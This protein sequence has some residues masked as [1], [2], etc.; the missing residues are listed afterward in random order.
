MTRP[1]GGAKAWR[2][3]Q[4]VIVAASRTEHPP[5]LSVGEVRAIL[6]ALLE[7]RNGLRV[8]DP[9]AADALSLATE[10]WQDVLAGRRVRNQTPEHI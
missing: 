1:S 7:E 3:P 4:G 10:Y 2:R 6:A 9:E 8:S 5:P